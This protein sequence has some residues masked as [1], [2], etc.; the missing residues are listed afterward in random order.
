MRLPGA[1]SVMG[2]AVQTPVLDLQG[3]GEKEGKLGCFQPSL[4]QIVL[5]SID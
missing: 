4:A 1:A 5:N 3:A 2:K